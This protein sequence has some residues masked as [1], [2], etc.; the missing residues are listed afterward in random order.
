MPHGV[1]RDRGSTLHGSGTA[2]SLRSPSRTSRRHVTISPRA[3]ARIRAARRSDPT[4]AR[5]S[6]DRARRSER[7]RVAIRAAGCDERPA[8]RGEPRVRLV[9]VG[10]GPAVAGDPGAPLLGLARYECGAGGGRLAD[11]GPDRI[12]TGDLQRDRLA[13][14]AATPRVRGRRNLARSRRAAQRVAACRGAPVPAAGRAAP[15]T[16]PAALRGLRRR[17][18][19][20]CPGC[21]GSTCAPTP[22]PTPPRRCAARWPRPSSATTSSATTRRSTPSRSG[23]PSCSARR[24]ASSSR[25]GRWATSSPRWPTWPAA[26]RSIAAATSHLVMDEA[27]GHAVVVGASVALPA[28]ERRTGRSTRP[29]S[30][31]AFR[32]PDD[33]HEPITGLDRHREHPRPLDGP[34][35]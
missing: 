2:P 30:T 27:A 29:R 13:C 14:W 3:A 4:P 15:A 19:L 18:A 22:S 7:R 35:L 1:G 17:P 31:A 21:P 9:V 16:P 28:R 32:D 20:S 12:R 24:P 23:R 5:R 34:A 6:A 33:P 25:P 10:R 8:P 11:G 26:R